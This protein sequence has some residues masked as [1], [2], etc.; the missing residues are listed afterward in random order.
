MTI[1][2]NVKIIDQCVFWDCTGLTNVIIPSSVTS[3][4]SY[5]FYYCKKLTD[6]YY[7]GTEEQWNKITIGEGL[8]YDTGDFTI[9]YNYGVIIATPDE[10]FTFT[11]LSD[12]TYSIAAKDVNNMPA[13]VIIP[14]TH[15]GKAVTIIDQ[16]AFFGCKKLTSITIPDSITTIGLDAFFG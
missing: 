9:T 8:Y 5:V 2:N 13:E 6:V 12:G 7:T 16:I 4:G 3:I 15:N 14:T 11:E 10:Y 1:G